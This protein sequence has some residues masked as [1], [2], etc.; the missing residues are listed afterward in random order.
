MLWGIM[1]NTV[2]LEEDGSFELDVF[3]AGLEGPH[4]LVLVTE[5]FGG[6]KTRQVFTLNDGNQPPQ[7]ILEYPGADGLY[8]S[9]L[10]V[11][12]NI[13]DMYRGIPEL[14][15]IQRLSY[16]LI[17][18]DRDTGDTVLSGDVQVEADNSFLFALDMEERSG[19][20]FLRLDA[21]GVNGSVGTLEISL[22]PGGSEI[23]SFAIKP[24]DG[25]LIL[26]W[27]PVPGA[28]EQT[29]YLTDDGSLP[30]DNAPGNQFFRS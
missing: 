24:Q 21:E 29:I 6:R 5:D 23:P 22:V 13:K 12:G 4:Q 26:S 15:G 9:M 25:R 3:T 28:E 8:G 17:P 19:R 14:E 2:F 18:R 1:I 30:S 27:E 7:I 10:S 16:S 11:M 20:Q